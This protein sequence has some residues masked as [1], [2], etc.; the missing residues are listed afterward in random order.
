MK[1]GMGSPCVPECPGRSPTCH[2]ECEKYR[3]FA[4][5]CAETRQKKINTARS[6]PSGPGLWKN[7]KEKQRREKQ[8]RGRK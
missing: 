2:A 6:T 4:E 8:G 1:R 5:A 3:A 7:V